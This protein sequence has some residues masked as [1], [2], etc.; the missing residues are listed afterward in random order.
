MR[1][2]PA[3]RKVLT[4]WRFGETAWVPGAGTVALAAIVHASCN[5][6]SGA[7]DL[8]FGGSGGIGGATSGIP[9]TSASAGSQG[10]A[11]SQGVVN[12][13]DA[14]W[15]DSGGQ[16]A[17]GQGDANALDA[18]GQG[19]ADGAASPTGVVPLAP[20]TE[21]PV[22][23]TSIRLGAATETKD[24][25]PNNLILVGFKGQRAIF[26]SSDPTSYVVS[27]LQPICT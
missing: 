1:I 18:A 8:A 16:D 24:T 3:A 2:S 22:Y 15:Q 21:M 23:S 17:G 11:S 20:D 4:R 26:N 12:R 6:I 7:N 14:G 13:Q 5:T 25:C 27:E 19:D 10:G 9:S